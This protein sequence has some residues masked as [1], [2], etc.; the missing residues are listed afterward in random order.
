MRCSSFR[1]WTPTHLSFSSSEVCVSNLSLHYS[2]MC[3]C[4][5]KVSKEKQEEDDNPE[6]SG[7]KMERDTARGFGQVAMS[8]WVGPDACWIRPG[9]QDVSPAQE[10]ALATG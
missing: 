7:N 5:I 1:G 6:H 10:P 2:Q 4:V 8:G 3:T 9:T